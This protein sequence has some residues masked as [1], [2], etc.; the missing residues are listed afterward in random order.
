MLSAA[1][2]RRIVLVSLLLITTCTTQPEFP[3]SEPLEAPPVQEEVGGGNCDPSYPGVCIPPS[4][5]DLDCGDIGFRRF[6]VR[7]PDP[8]HFD[9]DADGIGCESG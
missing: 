5:P 4:P 9:G 7:A 6:E 1:P 8:H 2:L 3:P